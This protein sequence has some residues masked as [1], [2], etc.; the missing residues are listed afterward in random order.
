MHG[1]GVGRGVHGDGLDPHFVTGAV[2]AKRNLTAIGDQ[3]FL[4]LRQGGLLDDDQGLVELDRL[5]VLDQDGGDGARLGRG[6]RVHH[7]H[8]LDDQ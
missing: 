5:T 4:D 1:I 8:G 2:D 7:L 6:D 3:E